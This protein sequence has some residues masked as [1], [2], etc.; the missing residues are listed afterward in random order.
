MSEKSVVFIDT[1]VNPETNE[2]RDY[3]AVT[4]NGNKIHTA[5]VNEF[6]NFVNSYSFMCGHNIIAHDLNYIKKF[7]N[8]KV[9]DT[10]LLSPLLFPERPYHAL[11]KDE[12]LVPDEKNNPL[13]D[14]VKAKN[15]FFEEVSAFKVLDKSLQN[16]YVSLL[17]EKE[18]FSGFWNYLD[19]F[20]K[21]NAVYE[22]FSFFHGDI[23]ANAPL[24]DIVKATPHN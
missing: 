21:G 24:E 6:E 8:I 12:K 3:G 17:Y 20:P 16:I 23:C 5:S 4:D 1:E 15:L 13:D 14:A 2:V 11:L 7:E 10:L 22:I 9:I 18:E 19:I